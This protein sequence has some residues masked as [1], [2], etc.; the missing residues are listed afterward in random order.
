MMYICYQVTCNIDVVA[1]YRL[2]MHLTLVIF[3][4]S[5]QKP[6]FFG[7]WWKMIK[8]LLKLASKQPTFSVGMCTSSEMNAVVI[9][10]PMTIVGSSEVS[11][12]AILNGSS[13]DSSGV[14]AIV[15]K[16]SMSCFLPFVDL[17]LLLLLL[18]WFPTHH[19]IECCVLHSVHHSHQCPGHLT[20]VPFLHHVL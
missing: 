10:L 9:G 15:S 5:V 20:P 7:L 19:D 4:I 17:C 6:F 18:E 12:M 11:S 14:Y 8:E 2:S 3:D 13:S 16:S 1:D